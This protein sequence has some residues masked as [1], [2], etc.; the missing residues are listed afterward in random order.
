[1][2][3]KKHEIGQEFK[4]DIWDA[5][6][7]HRPEFVITFELQIWTVSKD[8]DG[9][10]N[11]QMIKKSERFVWKKGFQMYIHFPTISYVCICIVQKQLVI[12]NF[13]VQL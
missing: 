1:M 11:G 9:D 6:H 3:G 2:F 5:K 12:M 4:V 10:E 13:I 7:F 8:S